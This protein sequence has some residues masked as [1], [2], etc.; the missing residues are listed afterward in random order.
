MDWTAKNIIDLSG[1]YWAGCALQAA[2]SLDVF[3][4]LHDGPL[5]ELSLA[6]HC[7]CNPRAFAMLMTALAA[8]GLV[9]RLPGDTIEAVP[10]ALNLLSRRSDEYLGFI[11]KHHFA[12]MPAWS[13]LADAV[14]AGTSIASR[15]SAHTSDDE[16]RESFLMGMFNIARHQAGAVAEA[17]D[18]T[19][20]KRLLDVG[21]GPGT[22]AIYFCQQNPWLKASIFDLP[23]TEP[24]ARKTI[25]Q[26]GLED[27]ICFT[28]GDFDRDTLPPG[29]D[30]AWLSQVLHQETPA[31][32]AKL[33]K[34][35]ARCVNPGGLV[36]IQEFML[37]DD[38]TGPEHAALFSLNMLVQTSGG[39]AYTRGQ[40]ADMLR[41]AGAKTVRELDIALPQSCRI[42]IG[43]F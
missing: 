37:D 4:A 5:Q 29:Q 20:R 36:C 13:Q 39:Q 2:V 30:V 26:Y 28:A 3:T 21:G 12:I 16:E 23:T 34:R 11:V 27:R 31:G 15:N 17:L 38:L 25:K 43:E 8:Q 10:T 6:A 35:A 18:L 24:F 9:K 19:G 42:L 22:Y 33:V 41:G 7:G 40:I 32:A 14:R 1:A